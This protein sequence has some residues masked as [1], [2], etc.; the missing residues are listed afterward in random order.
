[1][2]IDKYLAEFDD[3]AIRN[4]LSESSA[5]VYRSMWGK[6]MRSLVGAGIDPTHATENDY[7]RAIESMSTNGRQP[8]S[9]V[10]RR[11]AQLI[12]RVTDD[13]HRLPS[14]Y[15]EGP[16]KKPAEIASEEALKLILAMPDRTWK[17]LR[18]RAI[19]ASM[20]FGGLKPGEAV[21]A[22]TSALR[23]MADGEF[24]FMVPGSRHRSAPISSAGRI[25]MQAWLDCRDKEGIRTAE[26][27]P[28]SVD[29]GLLAYST[30]YRKIET[31]MK[32][33]GIEKRLAG[34]SLLRHGFG[35][36]QAYAGVK[37]VMIKK[38][39]GLFRE[40]SVEVYMPTKGKPV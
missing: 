33:V 30:V 2:N 8:A 20:A 35:Y 27:F 29:G 34:G 4:S 12:A 19:A 40:K 32:E 16:R 18:D 9:T 38:W 26:L 6:L 36:R 7:C 37:P 28:A 15:P 11:Y 17:H 3:W 5:K 13:F 31:T 39:M 14:L 24:V 22:P 25:F 10:C 21:S 23:K 1:M